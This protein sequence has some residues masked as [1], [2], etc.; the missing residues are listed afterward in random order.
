MCLEQIKYG[1]FSS[2]PH[3]GRRNIIKEV[4][5]KAIGIFVYMAK[6]YLC[7][8]HSRSTLFHVNCTMN[9]LIAFDLELTL[10][11]KRVHGIVMILCLHQ[12]TSS[13]IP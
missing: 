4:K 1:F 2:G 6:S 10:V 13:G 11:A 12:D 5:K 3:N 9:L 7:G 8:R